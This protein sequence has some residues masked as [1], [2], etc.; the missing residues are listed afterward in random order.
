MAAFAKSWR[1]EKP[2]RHD[3]RE[4]W[5]FFVLR[6]AFFFPIGSCVVERAA[7]GRIAIL[8]HV[9]DVTLKE[10][11]EKRNTIEKNLRN[12][13]AILGKRHDFIHGRWGLSDLGKGS[14]VYW[15]S[16]PY[17]EKKPPRPVPLSELTDVVDGI[18]STAKNI[19]VITKNL[20]AEWP[21][22]SWR[23]KRRRRQTSSTTGSGRPRS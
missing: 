10:G 4:A 6:L 18:R 1:S 3:P 23:P 15:H 9:L 7:L 13:K 19:A 17:E 11:S 5:P 16:V 14:E 21:P 22:Y 12:A 8:E 2:S 20:Y